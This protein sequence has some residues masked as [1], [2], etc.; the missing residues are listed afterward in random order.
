VCGRERCGQFWRWDPVGCTGGLS[1]SGVGVVFGEI[2]LQA[3]DAARVLR[4]LFEELSVPLLAGLEG[5]RRRRRR[6]ES[7]MRAG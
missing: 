6:V 7:E 4:D 5:R 1:G 2:V 3:L